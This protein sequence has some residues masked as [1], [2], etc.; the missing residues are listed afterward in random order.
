VSG[1]SAYSLPLM[2]IS[3]PTII[4]GRAGTLVQLRAAVGDRKIAAWSHM[5]SKKILVAQ[6]GATHMCGQEM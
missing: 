3:L 1:Y 4:L 2:G 6:Y 5:S